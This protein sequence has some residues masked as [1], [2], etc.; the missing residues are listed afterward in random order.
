M[1][2]NI[3][4]ADAGSSPVDHVFIPMGA[5]PNG[6]FWWVD[7]SHSNALGYWKIGVSLRRPQQ[8]APGTSSAD[9]NYVAKIQLLEP[10]LANVTNSTVTGV[11]PAP[12]LAYV[13]RSYHEFYLPERGGSLDRANISKMSALLLAEPQI[14]TVIEQLTYPGL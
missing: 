12:V 4:I 2:T 3:T 13:P 10:V 9:R 8:A 5:D 6:T 1:A 11:E 7:Q 14:K